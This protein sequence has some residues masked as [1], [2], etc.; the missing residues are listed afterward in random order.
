M[1]CYGSL[2]L[3]LATPHST[4]HGGVGNAQRSLGWAWPPETNSFDWYGIACILFLCRAYLLSTSSSATNAM[5]QRRLD[6]MPMRKY[7]V[8]KTP[9]L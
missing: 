9:F 6:I 8:K 1:K 5:C 7:S 3:C 2:T 4:F